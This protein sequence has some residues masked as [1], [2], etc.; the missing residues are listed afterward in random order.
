MNVSIFF[1]YILV[2]RK[3][4]YSENIIYPNH[5]IQMAKLFF[6]RQWEQS[7]HVSNN[8]LKNSIKESNQYL[9]YKMVNTVIKDINLNEK[10]NSF[11]YIMQTK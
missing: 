3:K 8:K 11:P 7:Y 4:L 2:P 9:Q 10:L 6:A 1:D 5:L